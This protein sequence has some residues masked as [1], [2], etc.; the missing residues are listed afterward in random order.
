MAGTHD[1]TSTILSFLKRHGEV[2][3]SEI[4]KKTGLSRAYVNRFFQQ[5]RR[6]G[7]IVLVGK[8]NQAKYVPATPTRVRRAK[9][10]VQ[11]IQRILKNKDLSEDVVLDEIKRDTGIFID[12]AE[13]VSRIIDYAFTKM[14]N[15]AIEHSR[16][17]HIMILM[18]RTTNDVRFRVKDHGIGIFNNIMAK[19]GLASELEAIQDLLKGKQTT[20]PEHHSGEGIF[21]TSKVAD[22]LVLRGSAKK[23]TYDNLLPDV[24]VEDMRPIV[25]TEVEFRLSTGSPRI[26]GDVFREYTTEEFDFGRTV[27]T[28][29]LY[30]TKGRYVSR[31]EARRLLS[32]LD[33]FKEVV[34]DFSGVETI[35]QGFADEVFR[36]WKQ[37]HPE[38]TISVRNANENVAFMIQHVRGGTMQ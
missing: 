23:L 10:R 1:I 24:F 35:G 29:D 3:T 37:H 20:E 19:R 33:E 6:E 18:D 36:V 31:S 5:L 26:L 34:I 7:K 16:S 28:V 9:R 14:L 38:I 15:N 8:A 2:R 13:N 17:T 27:V 11:K 12:M 25:G 22:R 21:F 30:K 4:V 32:G